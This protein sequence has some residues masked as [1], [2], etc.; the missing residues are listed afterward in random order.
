[1]DFLD[2]ILH[3]DQYLPKVMQEYG[4]I[5]YLILFFI[6]FCETGLVVAPF[7]PGDSLLF[8]A[9][10]FSATGALDIKILFILL[11][12]AAII[13]DSV[14]YWMGTIVGPEI[15]HKRKLPLV[16]EGHLKRTE[17][18]YEKHGGKTII[19]ARFIPVIRTFAPFVAGIG[20]MEYAR[21]M[22]YNLIGAI[23]WNMTFLVSG[24]YFGNLPFV[25]NNFSIVLLAII[26]V[27]FLPGIIEVLKHRS[28]KKKLKKAD[29]APPL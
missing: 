12:L 17:E 3:I 1:M 13:G 14:N 22:G 21:F 27:S 15:F 9:G 7:L 11:T 10:A 5:T 2:I 24:Y 20:K 19:L 18:F 23:L 6:I 8:A 28:Q 25:K 26:L 4:S 29:Q 16:N